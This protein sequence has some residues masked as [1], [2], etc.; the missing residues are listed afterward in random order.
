MLVAGLAKI[1]SRGLPSNQT[2]DQWRLLAPGGN[3]SGEYGILFL[4]RS[5]IQPIVDEQ[6]ET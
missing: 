4:P 1:T 3:P 5:I 2:G 6:Q